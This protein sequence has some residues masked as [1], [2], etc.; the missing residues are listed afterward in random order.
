MSERAMAALGLPPATAGLASSGDGL[1]YGALGLPLAFVAL[2]LYVLLPNHYAAQFGVPLAA[3]G[4]VLLA[5]RLLDALADPLIGRWVDR[6]FARKVLSAWWAATIA[7]LVLATGFRALF[8]PAVEGTAALLAWCSIGLVFTYLGYSV[9][10]VVHQAWGARLGGDEAGRARVVAWR[11]GA[12]VVGVL[13]ASVLPSASGLQATTL[14]FA[15][16]LL[17]G[18]AL[19]R[20]AP[21]A[22]LRPPLATGGA[23]SVQ[24]FRVTAF[25]RL[26]AIFIVNGIASAVPA[27]LVLFFIRDRLQAPAWEPAFLAAY[28]A[29]G[30]LSIPLWLRSVARFGLARSWLAG[31]GLAIATFG[32]AATLGAGDTLGFLAV[33]IASGA[34][35][36]ADLTLPGALLTGV[37][38][39]AGHAGHG[40]G[41]YLGWW[42]FATKLNL[43]LA[44]G[45]ALPL[46]QATGYETGARDPQALA[47]LSFAYCLLPCAL[48]LGAALLLWALW[49]R[50]PDAG[51]FA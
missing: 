38:Q 30:A 41:A 40:E 3:L 32:W 21:R 29:A 50:H 11:E 13:I 34:A 14:V 26:L 44:A 19:L 22:V 37:I 46:L 12:A 42:N 33:C 6:L 24:P 43:A 20:Q 45:V 10:S 18:L 47:A 28:F 17:A 35:L 27:T 49:L 15:V 1:R 25:R 9:V 2:P 39:R 48:K 7:A 5:A 16:L 4:A 36:G 31:M 23:A 8:F 51:D